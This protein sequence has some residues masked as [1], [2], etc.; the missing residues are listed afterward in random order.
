[1]IEWLHN[2]NVPCVLWPGKYVS[3]LGIV[4][5]WTVILNVITMLYYIF[6]SKC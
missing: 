6:L 1:M 5:I 4:T 3:M 2:Y